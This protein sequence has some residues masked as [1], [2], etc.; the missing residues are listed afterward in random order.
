MH[1]GWPDY[2]QDGYLLLQLISLR[3]PVGNWLIYTALTKAFS[4]SVVQVFRYPG[5]GSAIC[6]SLCQ[7]SGN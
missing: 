5:N 3:S 7:M 4:V 1:R 2:T 6:Q